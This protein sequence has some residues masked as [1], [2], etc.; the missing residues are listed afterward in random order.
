MKKSPINTNDIFTN[1]KKSNIFILSLVVFLIIVTVLIDYLFSVFQDFSFYLSESLMFSTF[2]L[3]F[4]PILNILFY[5]FRRTNKPLIII[6]LSLMLLVFHFVLYPLLIWTISKIFYYHTF[7]YKQTFQYALT[8]YFVISFLIFGSITLFIFKI[9]EK[10]FEKHQIADKLSENMNHLITSIV[11]SDRN[12]KKS[13]ID[14]NDILYF[15]ASSPYVNI[16][17]VNKKH[18]LLDTLKALENKLDSN[19]FIRIHKSLL[20]NL[21]HVSSFKSRLNGDYDLILTDE[22]VLRLSRNYAVNFKQ[23]FDQSHRLTPQKTPL[24]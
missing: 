3:L 4:L 15:S 9:K 23:K 7:E 5:I 10:I 16:H 1:N 14:T 13:I 24:R 2:W 11:V 6:I 18:L 21:N 8:E 17:Q 19:Q 22:T 20:I 12:K